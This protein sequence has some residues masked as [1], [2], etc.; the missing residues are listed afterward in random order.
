MENLERFTT[1]CM[2]VDLS[3]SPSFSVVPFLSGKICH[4]AFCEQYAQS[5]GDGTDHFKV[6]ANVISSAE[7]LA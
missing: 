6:G 5:V 7:T 4:Q 3:C 2:H 1:V